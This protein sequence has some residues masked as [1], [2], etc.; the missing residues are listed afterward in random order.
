[1]PTL[2]LARIHNAAERLIVSTYCTMPITRSVVTE[3]SRP[4]VVKVPL[5]KFHLLVLR[6]PAVSTTVDLAIT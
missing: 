5:T 4:T 6:K 2:A 3:P 1:M